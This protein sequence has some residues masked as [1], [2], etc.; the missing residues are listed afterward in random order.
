MHIFPDGVLAKSLQAVADWTNNGCTVVFTATGV[1]V[2][3]DATNQIIQYA[4]K[5]PT[6]R[7]WDLDFNCRPPATCANVISHQTNA[8][9][10]AY[11]HASFGSPPTSTFKEC[12]AKGYLRL[13]PGLTTTNVNKN[14]PHTPATSKGHL[15]RN[16]SGQ[17]ST[18]PASS[19]S[20]LPV[21]DVDTEQFLNA[22]VLTK[23]YNIDDP[24]LAINYSDLP[25]KFPFQS[26]KGMNYLLLS[27]FKGYIHVEAM[28]DRESASLVNAYRATYEFF[29]FSRHKPNFQRL[30]NETSVNLE[31]FFR[32]E[33]NVSFQYLPPDNH[34]ANKAERH[35]R[36]F[37]NHFISMLATVHPN[38]PMSLWDQFLPQA[39]ITANH[40]IPWSIDPR[41]SAYEGF[42]GSAFDFARHPIAPVG[43]RVEIYES[44][45]ARESWAPHSVT[46]HY[47]GPA[48][49]HYRSYRTFAIG[50][51]GFRTSDSLDWFPLTVQMPGSS[52]RDLVLAGLLDLA[53]AVRAAMASPQHISSGHPFPFDSTMTTAIQDASNL[54][55]ELARP[56]RP[57]PSDTGTLQ[58]VP[59]RA[60]PT[61][62]SDTA[63]LQRVPLRAVPAEPA[64][65]Q[66]P[67]IVIFPAARAPSAPCA[68]PGSTPGSS[69]P[70][71]SR[72]RE[73]TRAFKTNQKAQ[74][75]LLQYRPVTDLDIKPQ[76]K[77]YKDSIGRRFTDVETREIFHIVGIDIAVSNKKSNTRN[78]RKGSRTPLFK[79]YDTKLHSSPPLL[80][81][82]YERT[83]CCEILLQKGK[84]A[85][86]KMLTLSPEDDTS[87][88][89][90]GTKYIAKAL[91]A[92]L[93][94]PS[95][96]RWH[97]C[98]GVK[99]EPE[100]GWH[101]YS[102]QANRAERT[103]P[104]VLNLDSAGKPLQ[105]SSAMKGPNAQEWRYMDG[106]EISRLI[107]SK[108]LAAIHRADC[109]GDR[110][111][112][113]TYYKPVVKEKWN[114]DAQ[115]VD[116]R[117]R[118]TIGGDR[119]NYPGAVSSATADIFSVKA[120]LHAV[121]SD[122][123]TKGTDTRFATLDIKDFYL[124]TPLQRKEY[125]SI[126]LK[127]IPAD[128]I[129]KYCLEPFI[130]N[131][132]ILF[133]VSKCMY[134]LPQAGLLSHNHLIGHLALHGY[135]QDRDVPC[136][137]THVSQD[138]QFTLVVD[139]FG[140]KYSNVAD[141]HELVRILEMEWPIKL[142]LTGSKYLGYRLTWE[143]DV[144]RVTL[145]MP[146]Y[147]PKV[148]AR[149]T[150]GRVLH[151]AD[152][153]ALYIPP[154]RGKPNMGATPA[155][156]SPAVTAAEKL[157]VMEV[158][159]S[160]LFYARAIDHLMLPACTEISVNQSCPTQATLDACWRVLNYAHT[161]QSQQ[162]IFQG[163]DMVLKIKSDASYLSRPKS[164]SVAGGFHYCGNRE[165][166]TICGVLFAM[167]SS[168]PTVCAAVSEA[169]YA[170]LFINAQHGAWERTVLAALGY[171]QA[172]STRIETDNETAKGI[173]QGT[174]KMKRSKAIAMRY[175]WIRDRVSCGEF[176]VFWAKGKQNLADF[177]TKPQPAW[178]HK[179]FQ[180]LLA[181]PP[182]QRH[183][184][185][186]D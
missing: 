98:N 83:R 185:N 17:R 64:V 116:R 104:P 59:P 120:L 35:I 45:E 166:D 151:G 43:T 77:H 147:L 162:L 76:Q 155:D 137:F 22:N 148:L 103:N 124:G 79:F 132:S 165:D 39:E 63:T 3:H 157:F 89:S 44:A 168:I 24:D 117:I 163:C 134:G 100:N 68:V 133:E 53:N 5:E 67:A 26:M 164:G 111:S 102:G 170:A 109:P 114:S 158:N 18:K 183:S 11:V 105:Y 31:K 160:M 12:V 106:V 8:D 21:D 128:I 25:G 141:V 70:T 78:S 50:T 91:S 179:E 99:C 14:A 144:N 4:P 127:Y 28:P 57:T 30:D 36:Y 167:S 16:R 15:D 112:D 173:A 19:S 41:I 85:Y 113:I 10:V 56:T 75:G 171:P 32:D 51:Q 27:S 97:W 172:V 81:T 66:V 138:L 150:S 61:V 143:Y 142:D 37:K 95:K 96:F 169:E 90:V 7:L 177:F 176:T 149:F 54:F 181:T 154:T 140:I 159:G 110:R 13:Y 87:A 72:S 52:K 101:P 118:G 82:D 1:T 161:H 145:E 60:D 47:L 136:L 94:P 40:F 55:N 174:C 184:F 20:F 80:D 38:C 34:R 129:S 29:K 182:L 69:H 180:S 33:A 74:Q 115:K 107:D 9:F 130:H 73:R 92:V 6:A 108:T 186:S 146:D 58:R 152:S 175:H 46:G 139:D 88:T 153:P 65:Q 122:R 62:P 156:T 42:H 178:R 49:A 126:P 23:L 135:I 2:T 123:Y 71:A 93:S 131:D 119:I 84:R 48:L 125:V 86:A 121:V